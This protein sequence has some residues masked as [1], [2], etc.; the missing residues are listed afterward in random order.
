MCLFVC[1]C[2]FYHLI[3]KYNKL[4]ARCLNLIQ[5]TFC[6][7]G[8]LKRAQQR[9]QRQLVG[10]N[11]SRRKSSVNVNS[12]ERSILTRSQ[13]S[14]FS[15][16]VCFFCDCEA[17]YRET[18]V[19]VR[20]FGAGESLRKAISLLHNEKLTVKMNTALAANDAHSIDIKYHKNCWSKNVSNV[21]RKPSSSGETNSI[22]ASE[23]AAKIEFLTMA[24]IALHNG[25][26]ATMSELQLAFESILEKNNVPDASCKRKVLKQLL[27]KEIPDTPDIVV[28]RHVFF[29]VGNAGFCE[30]TPDGKRTFHGTAM[31]IYQ[32]TNAQDQVLDIAVDPKIQSRSIKDLPES[33]TE[34]LE[35]PAPPSKPFTPVYREFHLFSVE[36]LPSRV[37]TQDYT[38]LLGRS[39]S[40]VPADTT[41]ETREH[42]D[43]TSNDSSEGIESQPVKST[44][45]PVWSAYNSM[46]NEP[47]PVARVGTPPLIAAP[48]YEW[49]TLLTV[50]MQAQNIS[51]KV[52]GP[53]RKTVVS[54]DMGLYQPAKKL[55]MARQDLRNIILRPGQLHIVMADLRTIGAFI[56]NSR[57]DMC[58]LGSELYGPATV[59][60]ILEVGHVK[61]AETAHMVTL[62]ALFTL[63]QEALFQDNSDV[64]RSLD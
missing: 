14:P 2:L 49:Q 20:T 18:L 63:Y 39:L 47:M 40:R 31:A 13:T 7:N 6:L 59:K 38:W 45:V 22:S 26:I 55:Q 43:D 60:Q 52:V 11:E 8:M 5:I 19:N 12:D 33:I 57:L 51:V 41:E 9:H 54:L 53:T 17:G 1:L 32:R 27:Q 21:L 37:R 44:N 4:K 15:K 25:K 58:W 62:Q 23:I 28:G 64:H 16:D 24:E 56:D 3:F 29:A 35:C 42:A 61:R 36:E 48:A 50:L 30:D 34:L 46:L 10:P